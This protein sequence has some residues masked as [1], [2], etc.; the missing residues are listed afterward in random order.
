MFYVYVLKSER[1]GRWYT[2]MTGNLE[3]RLKAHLS[4]QV[5]STR[6]R[7]PLILAYYEVCFSEEDAKRRERYLKSGR[8]K[9]YL[10]Q[11]PAAWLMENCESKPEL[12]QE[13]AE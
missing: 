4:G 5:Y 11:R 9:H 10:R 7:N 8:G 6:Y 1:D 3:A 2:G 13:L 12:H